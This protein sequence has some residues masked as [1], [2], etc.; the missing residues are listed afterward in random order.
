MIIKYE[1]HL[2]TNL[3]LSDLMDKLKTSGYK[4]RSQLCKDYVKVELP[5]HGIHFD[6]SYKEWED[7]MYVY[8]IGTYDYNNFQELK[9]IISF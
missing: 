8:E 4:H 1:M 9:N 5:D 3:N 6:L 2:K 7:E